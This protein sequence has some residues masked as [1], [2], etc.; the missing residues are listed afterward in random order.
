MLKQT[1]LRFSL[2][3]LVGVLLG[4][5]MSLGPGGHVAMSQNSNTLK[6]GLIVP[7]SKT[8]HGWNE[9]AADSLLALEGPLNIK[10]EIAE[11]AG[12]GDISP[13]FLDFAKRGFDLVICHASGYQT[14][15]PE[16]AKQTGV[17]T[18]V[19]ENPHAVTKG[20]VSDYESQAQDVAYLAG[21]SAG[22]MTKTNIVG[23]VVS[24]EPPTWNFITTGFA[25]GLHSVN[26]NA[27]LIYTLIGAAAYEDVADAKR[28]TAA[29]LAAGADVILGQGDGASFGMM[30]AIS[31]KKKNSGKQ[32]WF[33]DVIGDKRSLDT[34]GVLLT[35]VLFD[36]TKVF[37]PMIQD[38]RNGDFGKV[39]TLDMANGGMRLLDFP[40]SVPAKVR[41]A[42]AQAKANI[43][44]GKLQVPAIS[45][46]G[47][48]HKLLKKLFPGSF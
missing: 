25:E 4:L 45:D 47:Q 43:L 7:A 32:V 39:Y 29:E 10:V 41:A 2:V 17:K 40:G 6:V 26:P 9:Q 36:F 48:M 28:D 12:Y 15:C 3:I 44:S 33:I 38:I 8:D 31:E 13:I 14:I 37:T 19:V 42:V 23:I 24:G 5:V 30:Q 22:L 11:Q 35:S 46:P 27:H 1:G 21:V 18:A 16:L 34:E 20:L